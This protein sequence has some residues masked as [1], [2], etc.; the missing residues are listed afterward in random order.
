MIGFSPITYTVDEGGTVMT[1]VVVTA[2]FLE[3]DVVVTVQTKD[4]TA[5][6]TCILW[7]YSCIQTETS[8]LTLNN[9]YTGEVGLELSVR[10]N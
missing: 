7:Q 9:N 8:L 3:R 6:G 2:G 1:T 10:V 5:T 4:G